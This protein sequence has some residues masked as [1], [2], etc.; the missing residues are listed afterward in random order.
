MTEDTESLLFGNRTERLARAL[1]TFGKTSDDLEQ[2]IEIL[3][4]WIKSQ[5]HLPEVPGTFS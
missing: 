3:I 5:P 2:D 1:N 4:E